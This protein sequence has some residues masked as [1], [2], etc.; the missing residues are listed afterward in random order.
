MNLQRVN[1]DI[2]RELWK[3]TKMEAVRRGKTLRR[4]VSELLDKN[5]P[6]LESQ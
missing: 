6:A 1:M 5:V 2:D 4:L 3:R